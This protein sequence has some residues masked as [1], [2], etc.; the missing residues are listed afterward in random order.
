MKDDQL[1]NFIK[2][3]NKPSVTIN[4]LKSMLYNAID[5]LDSLVIKKH[6]SLYN[7]IKALHTYYMK[8]D[9]SLI[10]TE[11]KVDLLYIFRNTIFLNIEEK[12]IPLIEDIFN[13]CD[14]QILINYDIFFDFIVEYGNREL[15]FVNVPKIHVRNKYNNFEDCHINI[16]CRCIFDLQQHTNNTLLKYYADTA[17]SKIQSFE[18]VEKVRKT[19]DLVLH[20]SKEHQ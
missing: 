3:A 12:S 10:S 1:I 4:E 11:R 6:T 14:E 2:L 7:N 17:M 19:C 9:N 20:Y 18:N 16:A 8:V 15:N 5:A 13:K